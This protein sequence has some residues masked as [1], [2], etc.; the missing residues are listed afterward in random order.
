MDLSHNI[1]D[2]RAGFTVECKISSRSSDKT[3][4]EV[5]WFKSQ[6]EGQPMTIFTAK[7]DGTLHSAIGDRRLLYS[8]P[9]ATLYKLTVPDVSPFDNGQYQC[10][11][12]EWLKTA[13]DS[14]RRV[15]E[16]KSGELN[17]YVATEEEPRTEKLVLENRV[18]HLDP[19]E[20][21]QF[22][23]ICSIVADKANAT[24][25]YTLIWLL[26]KQGS[27]KRTVLLRRTNDGHL[28]YPSEDPQLN[29][30]LQFSSSSVTTFHLT[31]FNSLPSD[32]GKYQCSVEQYQL[33]CD[34]KWTGK[35]SAVS[36][37]TTVTVQ[38]IGNVYFFHY[39]RIC[40][41]PTFPQIYVSSHFIRSA[42]FNEP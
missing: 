30:R 1:S 3:H 21:D 28:L 35:G 16:D 37:F 29:S 34:G 25:R 13:A 4:F 20:G 2:R 31:I 18:P 33:G 26:V 40:P 17:V 12:V 7:Q 22:D 11:V 38:D 15:A 5:T 23:V 39:F 32:S 14:W 8:H 6:K 9:S 41:L 19:A 24:V 42:H 27:D 10:Q 36:Q